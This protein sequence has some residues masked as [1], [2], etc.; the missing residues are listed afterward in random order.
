VPTVD[1]TRLTGWKRPAQNRFAKHSPRLKRSFRGI[2]NGRPIDPKYGIKRGLN[3]NES[4]LGAWYSKLRGNPFARTLRA[5][6]N[7]LSAE[8][9]Q[10]ARGAVGDDLSFAGIGRWYAL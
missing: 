4:D 6:Q 2:E 5:S 1:A 7:A 9:A 10:R 8:R 3:G